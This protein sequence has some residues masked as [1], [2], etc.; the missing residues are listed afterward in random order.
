MG[1]DRARGAA[2]LLVAVAAVVGA[3]YLGGERGGPRSPEKG[4]PAAAAREESASGP[5]A[6]AETASTARLPALSAPPAP[7]PEPPDELDVWLSQADAGDRTAA[8]RIARLLTRC[9]DGQAVQSM[10]Q[11]RFEHNV[12]NERLDLADE[13]ARLEHVSSDLQRG[14]HRFREDHFANEWRYLARSAEGG[15]AQSLFEFVVAPPI[16]LERPLQSVDAVVYY[17]RHA[18]EFVDRLVA[19]RSIEGLSV[20]FAV[21]SGTLSL[22]LDPLRARSPADIVA[23]GTALQQAGRPLTGDRQHRFE[24]AWRELPPAARGAAQE[25]GRRLGI[26][27]VRMIADDSD[28]AAGHARSCGGGP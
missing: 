26:G 24:E 6:Q 4:V 18:L 5:V 27:T 16:D 3:L 22:G 1:S 14:C 17:R 11:A 15:H 20:A 25:R 10:A 8:C 21:A 2:A 12:A 7:M 19:M 23:Y 9:R 13:I 28:A